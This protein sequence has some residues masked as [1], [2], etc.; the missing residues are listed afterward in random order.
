MCKS[1][2]IT[3]NGICSNIIETFQKQKSSNSSS[4]DCDIN[5]NGGMCEAVLN[6][7]KSINK[8]FIV[9]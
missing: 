2:V 5:V 4:N 1:G 8:N 9:C 7:D 6:I 3:A